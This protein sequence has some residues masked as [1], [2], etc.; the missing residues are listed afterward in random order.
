[1]RRSRNNN[2][3]NEVRSYVPKRLRFARKMIVFT[4]SYFLQGASRIEA[5]GLPLFRPHEELDHIH[6]S[7]R[8]IWWQWRLQ[9]NESIS[10]VLIS[11][12]QRQTTW[13]DVFRSLQNRPKN[14]WCLLEVEILEG[15]MNFN[16]SSGFNTSSQYILLRRLVASLSNTIQ[17]VQE[18]M[19]NI[20]SDNTKI[21]QTIN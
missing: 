9:S 11:A 14:T 15:E 16:N 18:T 21:Y 6:S 7:P 5:P 12:H 19:K 3:T 4:F 13:E 17:V 2:I 20:V 1:M 8:R 10:S